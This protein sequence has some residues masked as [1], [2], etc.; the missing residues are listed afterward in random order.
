MPTK[1][2]TIHK[3]LRGSEAQATIRLLLAL[4]D[5]GGA[6]KQ[7]R[8]KE[9]TDRAKL[10]TERVGDYKGVFEQLEKEG[11]IAFTTKNQ[12]THVSMTQKGLQMLD[13]GI[14][15]PD[16]E[17][18]GKHVRAKDVHALLQ[19]I[20]EKDTLSNGAIPH[21]NAVK[22]LEPT[23]A[24]YEDFK[25]EVLPLFE[26]LDKTSNYSGLVPIWHLRREL[27]K[28]VSPE[29]FNNWMME[30]QAEQLFYLQSGEARGATDDQKRDSIK[31]EIRGLLFFA[32]KPS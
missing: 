29:E 6:E 18:E 12:V 26:R 3:G 20:R 9:L 22:A 30:M 1:V 2:K 8:K 4:W 15:S 24:S 5:M 17:F 23:I 14:K 25:S 16:F 19:W 28:R 27:G 21:A 7:V 11:A 13:A 32:S 10:N 31:S